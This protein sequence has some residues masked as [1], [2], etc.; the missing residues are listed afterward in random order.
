M[1]NSFETLISSYINNNIGISD[2]FLSNELSNNLKANLLILNNN[3]QLKK[4]KIG[5]QNK[6]NLNSEIRND[7]I[8]WLDKSNNNVFEKQFFEQ[9]D[10]FVKYL[11]ESCFAGING[12]EFH[13]TIYESGSFYRKH[14]DQFHDDASRQFSMICYLNADWILG[15]G[16]ELL[17]HQ[18]GNNFSIS[19][20]QGKTVFFKSNEL[21]HEVLET[22]VQRLSITGWLKRD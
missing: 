17:I 16:G 6:Q 1:E 7:K 22:N 15:N 2:D 8:L 5:N 3:N 21:V 18:V 19:P 14:L 11:N 12:Y 20:N 4:A 13:Y 9:I 10:L